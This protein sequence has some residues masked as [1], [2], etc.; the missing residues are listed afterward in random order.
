MAI[1]PTH[2]R[3]SLHALSPLHRRSRHP[4]TGGPPPSES[5]SGA[6]PGRGG[7]HGERP[8]SHGRHVVEQRGARSLL[9]PP[10]AR[11]PPRHGGSGTSKDRTGPDP[12]PQPDVWPCAHAAQQ[13]CSWACTAAAANDDDETRAHVDE[14]RLLHLELHLYTSIYMNMND[15]CK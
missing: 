1:T 10:H 14:H 4:G 8:P 7:A 2:P 5:A 15:T 12:R 11:P 13:P 3:C 9:S 6:P